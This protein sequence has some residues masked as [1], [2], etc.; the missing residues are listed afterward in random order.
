MSNLIGHGGAGRGQGRKPGGLNQRTKALR[1]IADE[2]IAEGVHPLEVMLD[3]MR[4]YH[5]RADVLQTA[6]LAKVAKVSLKSKEA[7]ELLEEFKE[8]G[9]ARMKAQSCAVDAAPYVHPRLSATSA[10]VTVTHKVEEA[11][12]AFKQIE[13]ALNQMVNGEIIPAREK[14]KEKA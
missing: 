5:E 7:M 8:L 2:A 12:Q 11:E 9:A 4:F 6:V 3:N 10:D 14:A 1:A 13:G